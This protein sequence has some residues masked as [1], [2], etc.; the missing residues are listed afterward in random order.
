MIG[1][2]RAA[3]A[4]ALL[5]CALPLAYAQDDSHWLLDAKTRC[6]VYD[7]NAHAGDAVSWSGGCLNG[8]AEGDGTA[9][10]SAQG[11]VFESFTGNFAHGVAQDGHVSVT[12]GDGWTYQ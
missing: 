8:Y 2:T 12:W 10:F 6:A 7:A 5:G 11:K 9:A 3:L 4:A 1:V